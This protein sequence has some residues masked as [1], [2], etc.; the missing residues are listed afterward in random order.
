MT[1]QQSR[2]GEEV[3]AKATLFCPGCQHQ[4]RYD[5]D[6]STVASRRFVRY[7]CP[8]CG[9]EITKQPNHDRRPLACR[10]YERWERGWNRVRDAFQAWRTLWWRTN[11]IFPLPDEQ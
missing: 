2:V 10:Q 5:G 4:S 3:P 8:E 6:W 11:V 9:T 7:Q 1:R